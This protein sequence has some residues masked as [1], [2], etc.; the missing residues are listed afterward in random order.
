MTT[1][2]FINGVRQIPSIDYV[3]GSTTLNLSAPPAQG[4]NISLVLADGSETVFLGDGLTYL[5]N[6]RSQRHEMLQLLDDAV[7][8]RENPAVLEAL[9]KLK[10][11]IELV[12]E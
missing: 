9:E 5:F 10:V 12:R 6:F 7:K 2:V 8:Y 1:S 3:L 4:S 11:V